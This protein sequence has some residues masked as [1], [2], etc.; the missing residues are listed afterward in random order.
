MDLTKLFDETGIKGVLTY[1]VFTYQDT[2]VTVLNLLMV[3]IIL[4]LSYFVSKIVQGALRR[5]LGHETPDQE[6]ATKTTNRLVHYLILLIGFAIALSTLG[7]NLGALFAAG[8]VF[9][10]GIG[11]AVQNILENFFSGLVLMFDRSIRP[12]DVIE[13]EDEM[14]RVRDI[15]VRTTTVTNL[16]GD[17]YIVPNSKLAQSIVKNMSIPM[18]GHRV[19]VEVGVH[20]QSDMDQVFEVLRRVT[21]EFPDTMPNHE[22]LVLMKEIGSSTVRFRVFVWIPHVW[23]TPRARSRLLKACWDALRSAGIVMAYD[24]LDVHFDDKIV[25]RLSVREGIP[26]DNA[27]Q[28]GSEPTIAGQ[29]PTTTTEEAAGERPRSTE[30]RAS[31]EAGD[32]KEELG[33]DGSPALAL[34][35]AKSK[36]LPPS[37]RGARRGDERGDDVRRGDEYAGDERLSDEYAGDEDSERR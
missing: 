19:H 1:K 27:E 18:R 4:I 35:Q 10:V 15:R 3:I 37:E 21:E 25:Q 33:A 6:A 8:A 5:A 26:A 31:R 20:Y 13:I 30:A 7:L 11:F 12:G 28:K 22:G 9:A 29:N 24:Q 14:V 2:D 16:D 23:S 34:A 32:A 36:P 17:E